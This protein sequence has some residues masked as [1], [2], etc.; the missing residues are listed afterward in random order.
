MIQVH[1]LFVYEFEWDRSKANANRKK[2]GVD[3]EQAAEVFRDP[4]AVTIADEEHSG[5]ELR[6]ITMGRDMS[7]RYIVVVH[8][9][10][11][12]TDLAAHIRLISARRPTR[13][14]FRIYE[15]ER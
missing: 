15:E 6:W 11:Q 1:G 4:L 2:H 7:G 14:E 5:T 9:Y 8:T 10:R 13:T 12:L 3:F